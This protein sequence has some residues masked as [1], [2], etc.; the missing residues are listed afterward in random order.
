M[1]SNPYERENALKGALHYLFGRG[2]AG[3]AGFLTVLLLVRYMD[4]SNYATYT[5]L[6]GLVSLCGIIASLGMERVIAR[7]VPEARL[8]RSA[9]EL[10]RIIWI[11]SA[12]RLAAALLIVLLLYVCWTYV[13]QLLAVVQFKNFSAGL[14]C[15]IVAEGLFQHFSSVLQSLVMQKTL[16][17]LLVIQWAGRLL[18][19]AMVVTLNSAINWEDSLWICAIPET[20]GVAGFIVVIRQYL[21]KLPHKELIEDADPD[22]PDYGKV[23][24]VAL[25]NYSFT[26]LAAPPQ[27][28][29]M[30]VLT[31]AYLPV[32]LVAAYGFFISVAEKVRQYTPLHF[33]YGLLEPVMIA[34]YLKDRDFSALCRRCQLIY[35][36]N[37]LLMVPAVAWVAV[38]GDS[39][40]GLITG[41]KFHGLSWI[42][43]L[44]MV[45]LTIG[46]HVVLLQLILNSLE[47][48]R[49]LIEGSMYALPAMMIAIVVSIFIK[50]IYLLFTPLLF[51][52]VM[53]SYLIFQLSVSN[54]PYQPS[55][56]M[57]GGVLLSGA[58]TFAAMTLAGVENIWMQSPVE[59]G[60]LT[61]V[62]VMLVYSLSIWGVRAIDGAEIMM[63]KSLLKSSKSIS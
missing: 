62:S 49:L 8:F 18:M 59:H 31:A 6:S 39:I 48:S 43:V 42:L 41:G 51:S 10:G 30:K 47:K 50:P 54:H 9:K 15:F 53:N 3:T 28:Y 57:L 29:F 35:K 33:F 44:V 16:T 19:I 38:A 58:I 37:L 21:Q 17:R 1:T 56:K 23:T 55:R 4:V 14:C 36:L 13:D 63:V 52:M 26:L 34:G 32:E 46:S 45:Q 11:T 40:V 2:V 60:V 7:Y 22:W 20:L 27:G 24:E 25:H 12:I 5:A 61:L